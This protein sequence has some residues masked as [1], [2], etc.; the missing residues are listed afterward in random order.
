MGRR[1]TFARRDWGIANRKMEAW[2]HILYHGAV[3]AY[4]KFAPAGFF[5]LSPPA[6]RFGWF[7]FLIEWIKPEN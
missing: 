7:F 3:R 5:L 6:P 1:K 4:I 2:V